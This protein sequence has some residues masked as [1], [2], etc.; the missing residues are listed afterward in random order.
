MLQ[1]RAEASVHA[2]FIIVIS[3]HPEQLKRPRQ[4]A[5]FLLSAGDYETESG[6][7]IVS[8]FLPSV[9]FI[10]NNLESQSHI[11]FIDY[12]RIYERVHNDGGEVLGGYLIVME[13]CGHVTR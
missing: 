9:D 6:V 12:L 1:R 8:D 3:V 10:G 4:R 13:I 7:S 5:A 11:R 2:P